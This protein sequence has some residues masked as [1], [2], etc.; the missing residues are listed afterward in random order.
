M[1]CEGQVSSDDRIHSAVDPEPIVLISCP[2]FDFTIK[3]PVGIEPT[4]YEKIITVIDCNIM[5]SISPPNLTKLYYIIL[6]CIVKNK[7]C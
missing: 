1:S 7:E 5:L 2:V 6:T 3:Y 4:K